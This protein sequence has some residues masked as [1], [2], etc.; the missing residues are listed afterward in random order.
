MRAPYEVL[1]CQHALGHLAGVARCPEFG[2]QVHDLLV[3]VG[4]DGSA[5]GTCAALIVSD[6]GSKTENESLRQ[7][8]LALQISLQSGQVASLV[9]RE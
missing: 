2:E 4:L 3:V 1:G 5:V 6:D 9:F 8:A 7:F